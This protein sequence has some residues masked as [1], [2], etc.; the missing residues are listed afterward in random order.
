MELK[1]NRLSLIIWAVIVGLLIGF[2]MSFYRTVLHNQSQVIG[3]AN[4]I[5]STALK[6]KGISNV[7]DLF[8]VMGFYSTNNIIYMMLLGSI[9]SI[10]LSSNILLKEEYNKTAEFL[11][12]KPITRKEIFLT[13]YTVF[14]FNTVALNFIA[15]LIGIVS[16]QL[17]KTA[18]YNIKTFLMLSFCTLLLNFL[19]GTI[20]LFVS[21]LIKRSKPITSLAIGIV[22]IC[23]FIF[24]ISKITESA[25]IFGYLSPFKYVN[26]DISNPAYGID[27]WQLLYFIGLSGL[28]TFLSFRLYKRKDIYT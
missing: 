7:R 25:D 5:P 23:Y 22:L 20:G 3:M 1:R 9:F 13:K 8:S 11:L 15:A 6:F 14:A 19:F 28:F 21:T 26:L 16:I 17:V 24:T 27:F 2:T 12:S 10:V 4:L 18:E